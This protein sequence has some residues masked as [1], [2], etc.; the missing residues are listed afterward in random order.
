MRTRARR[1]LPAILRRPGI[2]AIAR[3]AAHAEEGAWIVGGAARDLLLGRADPDVDLAVSADPYALAEKLAR[4]GFGT[5][6]PLSDASP[7]VARLAGRRDIDLA[8]VEGAGISEDLGRRDFT[9]NA[10]AIGLAGREWTDPFGG[11]EDLAAR[12]LHA[13]SEKN[14]VEDPL[15]VLRGARLMATHGLRPDRATTQMCR[16]VAPLLPSAAPERIRSE[17]EKLLAA[18]KVRPAL[19]WAARTRV[20]SAALLRDLSPAA[21]IRIASTRALDAPGLSALPGEKRLRLRLALVA[22]GLRMDSAAAEGWLA[23]LRFSRAEAREVAALLDLVGRARSGSGDLEMWRWVRD[24]GGRA[25]DALRLAALLG[26][27]GPAVRSGLARRLR[28]AKRPPRVTGRDIQAWLEI[29]PGPPVGEALAAI[30]VEGMRGA[31]RSRAAAR[32]WITERFSRP[33]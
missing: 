26:D 16:R 4:E 18:G 17:L 14:L 11:V 1:A 13:I 2:A 3:A 22:R 24:A 31:I 8:A 15:R 10:V 6:V 12:R 27:P 7:R 29:P 30:E 28:A 21:A 20:L 9:V 19:L 25:A 23:S 33:S 5:F 32:K